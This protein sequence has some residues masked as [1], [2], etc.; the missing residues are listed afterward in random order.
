MSSSVLYQRLRELHEAGLL[1][2]DEHGAYALTPIGTALAQALAPLDDWA[3]RWAVA[4]RSA[5]AGRSAS[6]HGPGPDP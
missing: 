4:T 2:R 1:E 3:R 6:V 5:A